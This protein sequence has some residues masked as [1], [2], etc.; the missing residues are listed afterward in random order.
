MKKKKVLVTLLL[1]SMCAASFSLAGCEALESL[2]G[3]SS[4]ATGSSVKESSVSDSSEPDSSVPEECTEHD[5]S[6][7]V[8]LEWD[9][10]KGEYEASV[11]GGCKNCDAPVPEEA[12][13]SGVTVADTATCTEAGTIT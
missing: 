2:L 11:K 5:W 1:A 12:V 6:E 13:L 8:V 9:D 4:S 10:F 3:S 7:V